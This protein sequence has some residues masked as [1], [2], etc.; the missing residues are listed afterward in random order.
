MR[1]PLLALA[2]I[3]FFVGGKV[4]LGG[5]GRIFLL[6]VHVVEVAHDMQNIYYNYNKE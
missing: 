4:R 2:L 6:F 3:G 5:R 1:S